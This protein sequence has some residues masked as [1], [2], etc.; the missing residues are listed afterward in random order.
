MSKA[1]ELG[2]DVYSSIVKELPN[3]KSQI[4]GVTLRV[5]GS[6]EIQLEDGSNYLYRLKEQE[7]WK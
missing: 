5:N 3:M 2:N 1:Q 4:V 7:P 6:I